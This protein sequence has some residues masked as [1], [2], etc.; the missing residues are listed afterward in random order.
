[1]NN[2]QTPAAAF[3]DKLRAQYC[4]RSDAQLAE[5]LSV[6]APQ[7]SKM[8]NGLLA[9]GAKTILAI[10]EATNIPVADIRKAVAA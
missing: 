9:V 5:L 10:H 7:I 8:R 3:F 2:H 4:F 1:M 6:P